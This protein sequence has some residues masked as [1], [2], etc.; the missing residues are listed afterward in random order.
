MM[1]GMK[2]EEITVYV[3]CKI[4]ELITYRIKCAVGFSDIM[5]KVQNVLY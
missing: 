4:S 5:V 1:T 3:I 2:Y